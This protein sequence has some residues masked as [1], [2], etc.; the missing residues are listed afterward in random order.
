MCHAGHAPNKE[1]GDAPPRFRQ[2]FPASL[3]PACLARGTRERTELLALAERILDR[4]LGA[5]REG[6]RPG[7]LLLRREVDAAGRRVWAVREDRD[8]WLPYATRPRAFMALRPGRNARVLLALMR[9][10]VS[11]AGKAAEPRAAGPS[12]PVRVAGREPL[13]EVGIA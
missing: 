11:A 4:T 12:R 5:I 10:V 2:P 6:Q 9:D 8:V 7:T 13:R 1:G 3:L